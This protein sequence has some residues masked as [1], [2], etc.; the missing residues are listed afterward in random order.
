[1]GS[2][3]WILKAADYENQ[4]EWGTDNKRIENWEKMVRHRIHCE[5]LMFDSFYRIKMR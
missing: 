2:L 3:E 1:M 4:L 5:S